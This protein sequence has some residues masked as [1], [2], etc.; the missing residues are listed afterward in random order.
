MDLQLKKMSFNYFCTTVLS[1][2]RMNWRNLEQGSLM[3]LYPWSSYLASRGSGKC[4]EPGT[5]VV[6]ADG[7]TKMIQDIK[8]GDKVMIPAAVGWVTDTPGRNWIRHAGRPASSRIAW[9]ARSF[10]AG[11]TGRPLPAR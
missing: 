1:N 5:Y 9:P 8:V 4:L 3:Q 7:S 6:M 11:G 10:I 2:F